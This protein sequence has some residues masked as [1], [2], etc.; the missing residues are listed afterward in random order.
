MYVAHLIIIMYLYKNRMKLKIKY[1]YLYIPNSAL[2]LVCFVLLQGNELN[3]IPGDIKNY[4][5]DNE[6]C[7]FIAKIVDFCVLSANSSQRQIARTVHI[8]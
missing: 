6:I 5:E 3:F 8:A 2:G 7:C 4:T 1:D